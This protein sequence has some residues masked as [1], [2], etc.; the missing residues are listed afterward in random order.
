MGDSSF[1]W[2][3][4]LSLLG[5]GFQR[6]YQK[7]FS[8]L[9]IDLNPIEFGRIDAAAGTRIWN[10]NL[11]P[12]DFECKHD[13]RRRKDQSSRRRRNVWT[14]GNGGR[15]KKVDPD[16]PTERP[17]SSLSLFRRSA[18][19]VGGAIFCLPFSRKSSSP[20]SLTSTTR[21][22]SHRFLLRTCCGCCFLS[23]TNL[24]IAF[25]SGHRSIESPHLVHILCLHFEVIIIKHVS[26][27]LS[28][29]PN[30][31]I[32][33]MPTS[34]SSSFL[35]IDWFS[36]S[37]N[38]KEILCFLSAFRLRNQEEKAS[39]SPFLASHLHLFFFFLLVHWLFSLTCFCTHQH[40]PTD[41]HKHRRN[42][43]VGGCLLRS[44]EVACPPSNVC[45]HFC[46]GE[47]ERR[48]KKKITI[49]WSGL[50]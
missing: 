37:S 6:F 36:N 41:S 19:G 31:P 21:H 45:F 42:S 4:F 17:T 25:I 15:D 20:F 9:A 11:A 12:L 26:S 3:T 13:A 30:P 40:G 46:P 5:K 29:S 1:G 22:S 35:K 48:E 39:L 32:K 47:T 14:V 44:T 34:I 49:C 38:K 18:L 28:L 24:A 2:P 33:S 10:S 7:V 27:F 16:D 43:S 8:R 23:L 50:V